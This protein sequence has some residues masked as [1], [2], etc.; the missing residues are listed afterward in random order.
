MPSDDCRSPWRLLSRS[1]LAILFIA[2]GMAEVTHAGPQA[3]DFY[4]ATNGNDAWSGT[5]L[6]PNAVRT[7]GPFATLARARDA[8]RAANAGD[9]SRPR[10]SLYGGSYCLESP[11]ELTAA[12]SGLTIQAGLGEKPVLYGGRRITG[13][14]RDGDRFWA[15]R[16]P[17]VAAGKWDFRLLV[18]DG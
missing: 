17:A 5:L 11:L 10:I 15:A 4:V 16:L 8:A 2:N 3:P 12:D 7:D 1:V 13:W 9:G 6:A 18:V 14:Q